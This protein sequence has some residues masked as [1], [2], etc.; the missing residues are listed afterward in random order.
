MSFPCE[1]HWLPS[2]EPAAGPLAPWLL[3]HIPT[4]TPV[5]CQLYFFEFVSPVAFEWFLEA[6]V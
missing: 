2:L 5:F 4:Q 1:G 6:N 3:S